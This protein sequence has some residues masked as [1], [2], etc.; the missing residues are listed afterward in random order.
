M[1][2]LTRA[3]DDLKAQE[4]KARQQLDAYVLRHGHAWPS[5]KSRWTR[6]HYNW[7]E[8]LRFAPAAD[9][10]SRTGSERAQQRVATTP[11]RDHAD[12]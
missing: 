12:R 9:G 2:D 10:L 6:T 4:R 1:R 3:R 8:S 5:N 7:L 11:G